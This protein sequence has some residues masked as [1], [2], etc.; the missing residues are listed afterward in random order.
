MF[1]LGPV[2]IYG[3]LG[4]ELRIF[5]LVSGS[6]IISLVA[7]KLRMLQKLFIVTRRET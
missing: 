3:D 6:H 2:L 7:A 4:A 5:D 1:V